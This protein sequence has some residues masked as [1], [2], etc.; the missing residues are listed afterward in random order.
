MASVVAVL[1]LTRVLDNAR[2]R[3]TIVDVQTRATRKDNYLSQA[4]EDASRLAVRVCGS[5][6]DR[7]SGGGDPIFF[8]AGLGDDQSL[9]LAWAANTPV[10]SHS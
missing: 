5:L 4:R 6:T 1:S 10:G 3:L 9:G 2:R 8:A 7:W